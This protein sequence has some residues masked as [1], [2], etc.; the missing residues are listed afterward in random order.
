MQ[1]HRAFFVVMISEEAS[2]LGSPK[3]NSSYF[4][5]QLYH[6][7]A[8]RFTRSLIYFQHSLSDVR[9]E[10]DQT[11]QTEAKGQAWSVDLS[12]SNV[13]QRKFIFCSHF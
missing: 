1:I 11:I 9:K 12:C 6:F 8:S 5:I 7:A 4:N 2:F 10:T 3:K 13:E